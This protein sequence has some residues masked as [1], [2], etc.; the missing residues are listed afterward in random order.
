MTLQTAT[1]DADPVFVDH[2][3]RRRRLVA[4]AATAGALILTL[5]VLALLAGFTGAGPVPVPGFP[6]ARTGHVKPT[7]PTPQRTDPTPATTPAPPGATPAGT[8]GP[9]TARPSFG[10]PSVTSAPTAS[11]TLTPKG[12]GRSPSHPPH[13]T[14][15]N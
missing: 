12:N 14:K 4:A 13:P 1:R 9:A 2:T 15:K 3:G 11:P 5:A 10:A 8:S 7:R 6:A